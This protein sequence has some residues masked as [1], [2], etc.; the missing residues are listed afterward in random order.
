MS[1]WI[2]V[3]Y[4]QRSKQWEIGSFTTKVI[5]STLSIPRQY[6]GKKFTIESKGDVVRVRL[7]ERG[8]RITNS[9]IGVPTA[10]QKLMKNERQAVA[11]RDEFALYLCPYS[12]GQEYLNA[13]LKKERII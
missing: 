6:R 5:K 4:G 1:E 12:K 8:L 9:G 3:P 10:V 7:D 2:E 11:Y 13:F